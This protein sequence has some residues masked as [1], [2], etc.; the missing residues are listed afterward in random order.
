MT[1]P[2]PK[3]SQKCPCKAG[4]FWKTFSKV[5]Q[6]EKNSPVGFETPPA[7]KVSQKP[8]ARLVLS[9]PFCSFLKKVSLQKGFCKKFCK[10]L[11]NFYFAKICRCSVN[12]ES[13]WQNCKIFACKNFIANFCENFAKITRASRVKIFA[14]VKN[15]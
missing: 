10:F 4:H 2:E 12:S 9:K 5:F 13:N 3:V 15:F 14:R 6:P 1:Q 8:G 7:A 11:Q